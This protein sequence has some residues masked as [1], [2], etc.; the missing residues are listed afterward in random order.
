MRFCPCHLLV[1]F[2]LLSL[3]LS[4]SLVS[5]SLF[6]PFPFFPKKDAR[7]SFA[8]EK[9]KREQNVF[10][11]KAG[12]ETHYLQWGCWLLMPVGLS[13]RCRTGLAGASSSCLGMGPLLLFKTWESVKEVSIS[14]VV[15][16]LLIYVIVIRYASNIAPVRT[17]QL[18]KNLFMALFIQ[19]CINISGL[20]LVR[21]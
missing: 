2:V 13:E 7:H 8:L 9:S 3:S 11:F 6:I 18:A 15:S 19:F 21:S 4:L 20:A 1:R 14:V 10:L 12:S 5:L 17:Q 16:G